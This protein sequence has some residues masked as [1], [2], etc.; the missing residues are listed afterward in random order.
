MKLRKSFVLLLVVIVTASPVLSAELAEFA[1]ETLAFYL[2][3]NI[4]LVSLLMFV[5]GLFFEL[6]REKLARRKARGKFVEHCQQQRVYR[7][8]YVPMRIRK[9]QAGKCLLRDRHCS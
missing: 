2:L 6:M 9:E 8:Q 3:V 1:S 5:S 7:R 4:T